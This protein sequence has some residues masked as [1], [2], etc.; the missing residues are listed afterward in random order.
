MTTP[1]EVGVYRPGDVFQINEAHGRGG[2]V[3]AFVM[4]DTVKPWGL[5]AFMHLAE[6][7]ET[8]SR[9]YIRL[10]WQEVDYIGRAVLIPEDYKEVPNG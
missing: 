9:A 5:Q 4:V 1:R 7:H 3:G 6:D 2:W 10:E 8:A